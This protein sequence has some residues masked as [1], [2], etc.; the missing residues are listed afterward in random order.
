MLKTNGR[1]IK[2]FV[3]KI[4]L[5]NGS[6][7]GIALGFALGLFLS[8]IPTFAMGMLLALALAPVLKAN[9]VSTYLGTAVVNPFTA[10]FFY[11]LDYFVGRLIVG[12]TSHITLPRT[13]SQLC[14]ITGTIAFPLYLGA[15]LVAAS[16]A[17]AS[18]AILFQGV[19]YYQK[20]EDSHQ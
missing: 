1:K 5:L 19:K 4:L 6:P 2:R 3:K 10:V 17:L 16:L 14:D 8:V 15:V 20:R 18:Y 7:H 9:L 13:F 11:G 12:G